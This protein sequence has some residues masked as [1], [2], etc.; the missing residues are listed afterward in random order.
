M[1]P[2][3]LDSL[4]SSFIPGKIEADVSAILDKGFLELHNDTFCAPSRLL[5]YV[6][7]FHSV[8]KRFTG[9]QLIIQNV[10]P[11]ESVVEPDNNTC[12]VF[13]PTATTK[14]YQLVATIL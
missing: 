6:Y 2:S 11:E 4:G 7:Y 12:I 3:I 5:T 9:G 13:R 14:Y 1:N 10:N 8:P